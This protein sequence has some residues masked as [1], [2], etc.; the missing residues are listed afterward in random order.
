MKNSSLSWYQVYKNLI[1]LYWDVNAE[2]TTRQQHRTKLTKFSRILQIL[3]VIKTYL[4]SEFLQFIYIIW[5]INNFSLNC[6]QIYKNMMWRYLDNYV[7]PTLSPWI[8]DGKNSIFE[9]P[10][11]F[12]S[13]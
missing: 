10:A 11:I 1:C 13:K 9:D 4:D 2:P 7:E 3:K 12:A 6:Y 8:P 5:K